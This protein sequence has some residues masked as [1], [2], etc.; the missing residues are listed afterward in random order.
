MSENNYGALMM[1]SALSAS[2]DLDSIFQPGFYIVP[3]GNPTSPDPQGGILTVYNGSPRRRTFTS[4][5][6]ILAISTFST[7]S[8][9]WSSWHYPYSSADLGSGKSGLGDN[10][11]I[12]PAK[13]L[14][15]T[16][17]TVN[18]H[19]NEG[20]SIFNWESDSKNDDTTRFKKAIL[21]GHKVIKIPQR[22]VNGPLKVAELDI[23][24][25]MVLQGEGVISIDSTGSTIIKIAESAYAIQF[26]GDKENRPHGG[27]LRNIDLRGETDSSTG[28][29]LRVESWSYFWCEMLALQNMAGWGASFRNVAESGIHNYLCRRLGSEDTGCILF[30]DYLDSLNNNVNNFSLWRGTFGFNSGTWIYGTDQSN[31]DVVSIENH[32]FEYDDKPVSGNLTQKSVIYLGQANRVNIKSN[33]FTNFKLTNANLY[34]NCIRIGVNSRVKP[35][36]SDNQFYGCDNSLLNIEGG[37][38]EG[39][40]NVANRGDASADGTFSCSSKLPQDIAPIIFHTNDGAKNRRSYFDAPSFISAHRMVG[41]K[42]N[43]FIADSGSMTHYATVMSVPA[44]EEIRRGTISRALIAERSF[45]H[46]TARMKNTSGTASSVILN[47]DGVDAGSV[48]VP[49]DGQWHN[50]TWQIRPDK[51]NNGSFI[52]TNGA[53]PILFDGVFIEKKDYFNWSFAWVPGTIEAGKAALSPVQSVTDT[54]GFV[55]DNVE[56]T[57]IGSLN[58]THLQ[59]SMD[60]SGNVVIICQNNTASAVRPSFTRARL[61]YTSSGKIN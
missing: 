7:V 28:T 34:T 49:A 43:P 20:V 45:V 38:V 36:I 17:R 42:N 31:L 26:S 5:L 1:K 40:G 16:E 32:K 8:Y 13:T 55:P 33:F 61:R 57:V 60:E 11:V 30:E 4:D 25:P 41:S 21:D 35:N 51:I 46:I 47:L 3:P 23:N 44:L 9:L 18:D 15:E 24:V 58:G 27:G 6:M 2:V 14:N 39:S 56:V 50:H 52:L 37:S 59:P 29:L 48:S 53:S 19:L 54:I 12:H 22:S 10:L